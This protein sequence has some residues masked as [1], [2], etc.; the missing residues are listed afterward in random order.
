[1]LLF[2]TDKLVHDF[3]RREHRSDFTIAN[4][5]LLEA[6]ER[7]LHFTRGL[8]C[9]QNFLSVIVIDLLH[10]HLVFFLPVDHLTLRLEILDLC[11][12]HVS[13]FI[14]LVDRFDH[15][16]QVTSF[17]AEIFLQLD[18]DLLE[19]YALAPQLVNFLSQ[20]LVCGHRRAVA[21]VSFV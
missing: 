15:A 1:M 18:V 17:D 9:N 12:G 14:D 3:V 13:V 8:L 5:S 11:N 19:D 2:L 4:K 16:R 10:A 21:L 6:L 7:C 20:Y